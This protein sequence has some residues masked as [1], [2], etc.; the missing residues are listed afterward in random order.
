MDRT[1][2]GAPGKIRAV[3]RLIEDYPAEIAY[4]WRS[5]FSLPI[6]SVFDGRMGFE[7]AWMLIQRLIIDPSS[8]LGAAHAG[9][10][11]PLSREAMILADQWDLTV[12]ANTDKKKH[13]KAKTYPRPFERKGA[14]T[15]SARPAVNQAEIDA[16]LRQRGYRVGK[17]RRG[18]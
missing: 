3:L 12:A 2:R 11:Y 4:D 1:D 7:E 8:H 13:G 14:T 18:N 10:K 15:K 17:E 5:R 6:E 16:A 9:W